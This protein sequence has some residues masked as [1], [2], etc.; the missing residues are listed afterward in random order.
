MKARLKGGLQ[1]GKQIERKLQISGQILFR[2]RS[3][4]LRQTLALLWGSGDEFGVSHLGHQQIAKIAGHFT[5][6]MLQVAAVALQV[7][8]DEDAMDR[9]VAHA[10]AL[11]GALL[12]ATGER[13]AEHQRQTKADDGKTTP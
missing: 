9:N 7:L 13:A 10:K 4:D 3:R 5:A 12:L 1:V 8:D 11:L 2:K 6:E